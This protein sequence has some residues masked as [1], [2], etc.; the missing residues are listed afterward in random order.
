M[1]LKS[2]KLVSYLFTILAIA[3]CT[4]QTINTKGRITDVM[5]IS[6]I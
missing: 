6:K 3:S 5:S 4:T 2:V 1:N